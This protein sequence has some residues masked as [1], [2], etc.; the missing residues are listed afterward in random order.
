MT[1]NVNENRDKD[2]V[3]NRDKCMQDFYYSSADGVTKIHAIEWIPAQNVR[4]VLQISHGMVEYIGR[5]ARFAEFLN[6]RGIYVVGND[7]LGHGESVAAGDRHGYFGHPYGNRYVIADIHRLRRIT[8]KKY[9]G[10]PYFMMGHSMGSFLLRQYITQYGSGL[11]GAI[12]MGTGTQPL[13]KIAS[14]KLLC[15]LIALLKGWDYRS[16]L[17]DDMAFASYNKRFEPS[18]TAQDWLTKDESIVDAYRAHPWCTFRFT[19]NA[20]YQMSTGIGIAHKKKHIRKIPRDLPILLVSGMDDPV[21]GFGKGVRR[22]YQTY[23]KTG[24]R[25]V[26][27]KLYPDDRHEILNEVDYEKVQEDLWR[28]MR[29]RLY[30]SYQK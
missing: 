23:K 8:S 14:A 9:P 29:R 17:V 3:E 15:R 6:S 7:H 20:Y 1:G 21:G 19:V 26:Q 18:R 16:K 13:I 27:I 10:V 5:Y 25:D 4:A 11:A 12:A 28:W 30:R 2:M 24:I 22:V